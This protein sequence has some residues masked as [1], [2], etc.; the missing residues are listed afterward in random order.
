[1]NDSPAC[2]PVNIITGFLGAGKT[3]LL[4]RLLQRGFGNERV[5]V[6]VND[7][8]KI[9]VDALLI[10]HEEEGI[11]SLPNGCICCSLAGD[12]LT[13]LDQL[14]RTG[15]DRIL[16][17]A[18]GLTRITDLRTIVGNPSLAGR[19]FLETVTA[20]IDPD[21]FVKLRKVVATMDEQISGANVVVL[22]RADVAGDDERN[23][24]RAVVASLNPSARILVSSFCEL[25]MDELRTGIASPAGGDGPAGEDHWSS[26]TVHFDTPVVRSELLAALGKLP[27]DVFRLKG[28]VH[29]REGASL[30]V[31]WAGGQGRITPW[32][33]EVPEDAADTLIVIGGETLTQGILQSV[34]SAYPSARYEETQ[35][36]HTHH[37]HQ[38]LQ[39][40]PQP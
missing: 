26:F 2:T 39:P 6:V 9:A 29:N 3:T 10:E 16:L 25:G 30:H 27:A 8:G 21:R 40:D 34:L 1:M 23:E 32:E 35:S 11:L 12:L 4:N 36:D 33:R 24:A 7:F 5:A 38:E 20:I 28:F 15:Y 14:L 19:C 22:N 18:S 13:G 17:E 37:H 31:E